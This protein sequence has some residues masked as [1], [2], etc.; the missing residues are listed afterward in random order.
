VSK[1]AR[2]ADVKVKSIGG[3]LSE[4]GNKNCYLVTVKY[5]FE[6]NTKTLGFL[7]DCGQSIP[8]REEDQDQTGLDWNHVPNFSAIPEDVDRVEAVIISHAHRDHDGGLN[9]LFEFLI[10]S[11]KFGEKKLPEVILPQYAANMLQSREYRDLTAQ[12]PRLDKR[13]AIASHYRFGIKNDFI[14]VVDRMTEIVFRV[15][16]DSWYDL[17]DIELQNTDIVFRFF[18]V[19]HSVADS[20]GIVVELAGKKLIYSGDLRLYGANQQ[21]TLTF[22]GKL[23]D[24][25]LRNADMLMLDATGVDKPGTGKAEDVAIDSFLRIVDE[26]PNKRIFAT[27][28]SSQPKLLEFLKTFGRKGLKREVI[29]HGGSMQDNMKWGHQHRPLYDDQSLIPGGWKR[30]SYGRFPVSGNAIIFLTGSQGE[31]LSALNRLFNPEFNQ[32]MQDIAITSEDI[33]V[34]AAR[35]IPGNEEAVESILLQLRKTGCTIYYPLD[36]G[37]T[38]PDW[39]RKA[40][41]SRV[42]FE[43]LHIS[44]HAPRDDL[45][46]IVKMLKPKA[47]MPIHAPAEQRAMMAE[48]AGEIPVILPEDL[49][50][51]V[52]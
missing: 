24:K 33:V 2:I 14:K 39:V 12:P 19:N 34:F 30:Y 28:F 13:W 7:L 4:I 35:T 42:I 40:A 41:G 31:P 6:S 44:G 9:K 46:E 17:A 32:E 49:E 25:N 1:N 21:E 16:D 50:E 8:Q 18:Q 27:M 48:I 47:L 29:L 5:E 51:V 26:N 20:L 3:G 10:N 45:Q 52:L 43:D 38:E 23:S 36:H 11:K 15:E 22:V 37:D